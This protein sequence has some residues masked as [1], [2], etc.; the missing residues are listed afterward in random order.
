MKWASKLF[1]G[2]CK[3]Q[4]TILLKTLSKPNKMGQKTSLL[5][6]TLRFAWSICVLW[7]PLLS[8]P[9]KVAVTKEKTSQ[10]NRTEVQ[11][12]SFL[13]QYSSIPSV[14]WWIILYFADIQK[15]HRW[16]E[17]TKLNSSSLSPDIK[18]QVLPTSL[19][20]LQ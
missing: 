19:Y 11:G 7:K 4:D 6:Q 12:T 15:E 20:K 9:D 17:G 16:N 5:I 13:H 10:Q 1:G 14:W 2:K 18:I 3:N 8:G